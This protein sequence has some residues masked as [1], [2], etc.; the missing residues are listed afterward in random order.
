[1]S[2]WMKPEAALLRLAEDNDAP[3]GSRV[4]ALKLVLHPP[5]SLLRRLLVEPKTPREKEI[6]SRLRAAATLIYAK[7][8]AL[9]RIRKQHKK[10]QG[11]ET[12][13]LGI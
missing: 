12:N 1:M 5:L 13:A 8:M 7:E 11:A 4:R 2:I 9:R 10:E 3:V 6:P